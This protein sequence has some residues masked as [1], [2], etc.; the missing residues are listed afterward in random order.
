MSEERT[1]SKMAVKVYVVLD[2]KRLTADGEPNVTIIDAKLTHKAAM[3]I[4][5]QRPGTFIQKVVATK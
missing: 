3:D 2:R 1:S 5:D 4:V